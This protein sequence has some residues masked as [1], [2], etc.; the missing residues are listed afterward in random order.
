MLKDGIFEI[1]FILCHFKETRD[2]SD[3]KLTLYII[4]F[5]FPL[6][7]TIPFFVFVGGLPF[8][9]TEYLIFIVTQ[10]KQRDIKL[11]YENV[12]LLYMFKLMFL[13]FEK[14]AV[15]S[16]CEGMYLCLIMV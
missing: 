5:S 1:D 8:I 9:V 7:E 10:I 11:F 13:V 15:F 12:C 14:S 16:Y 2:I 3:H 4:L 6:V